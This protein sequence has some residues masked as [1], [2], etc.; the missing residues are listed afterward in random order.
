MEVSDRDQRRAFSHYLRTGRWPPSKLTDAIQF[1]FNPYHDPRDGKFTFGPGTASSVN[2]AVPVVAGR[3]GRP[4]ALPVAHPSQASPTARHEAPPSDTTR[5]PDKDAG[6]FQAAS[7]G[8]VPRGGNMRAFEDPMTLQQVF[9]G[10]QESPGGAI[11]ALADN[12]LDLTGPARDAIDELMLR[13]T[14]QIINEIHAIDP[15]YRFQSFGFPS[16]LEGQTSQLNDLKFDRAI[17]L[18]RVKGEVGPLQVETLRF[19][20]TRADAAYEDGLRRLNDGS[21]KVHISQELTLGNFV[22]REVR[23]ALRMRYYMAGIETSPGSVVRVNG[24]EYDS[25]NT[26]VTYRRPDARV[27]RVAFDVTLTRKTLA[28]PQVSGF[29]RADFNPAYVVIVRPSQLA[30]NSTYVITRPGV[31]K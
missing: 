5:S 17:A 18:Y 22:D 12:F 15:N 9:P 28:T 30:S 19:V 3:G 29:F 25:S 2:H 21:L 6:S 10:L 16:T 20:Q 7:L 11:I 13:R 27:G 1:K 4:D 31:K 24:R 26:D 14:R 23:D 8:R